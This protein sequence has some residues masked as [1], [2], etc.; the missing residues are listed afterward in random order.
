[1]NEGEDVIPTAVAKEVIGLRP[2]ARYPEHEED[3]ALK[4]SDD[5]TPRVAEGAAADAPDGRGPSTIG[6]N[7]RPDDIA[8]HFVFPPIRR[9]ESRTDSE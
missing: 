1:M 7:R 4:G 9:G 5:E 8:R 6:G 3:R 2:C